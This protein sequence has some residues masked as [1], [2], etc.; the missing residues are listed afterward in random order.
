MEH[1]S[2]RD[3]LAHAGRCRVEEQFSL[4]QMCE[5]TLGVYVSILKSD[6]T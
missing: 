5:K 3:E 2:R 1:P 4:K 6:R